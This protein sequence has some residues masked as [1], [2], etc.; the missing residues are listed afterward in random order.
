[1]HVND[2]KTAL[3]FKTIKILVFV[4]ANEKKALKSLEFNSME[5]D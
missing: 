4:S 2:L 1:M 5:V 3:N